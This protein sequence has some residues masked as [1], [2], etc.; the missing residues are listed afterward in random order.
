MT[1]QDVLD[2]YEAEEN[3]IPHSMII[4]SFDDVGC[5]YKLLIRNKGISAMRKEIF[6][7][8]TTTGT[9]EERLVE[10]YVEIGDAQ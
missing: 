7:A 5:T 8:T 10:T 4:K 1:V 3:Y 2:L 9:L 6:M